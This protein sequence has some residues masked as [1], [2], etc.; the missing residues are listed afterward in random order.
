MNRYRPIRYGR[1]AVQTKAAVAIAVAVVVGTP[2]IFS[3]MQIIPAV[4]ACSGLWLIVWLLSTLVFG[5][6]YCSTVCP[7]GALT[8]L[9]SAVARRWKKSHYSYCSPST[10]TRI[11][12]LGIAAISAVTGISTIIA[13][14]D[15][16][17]AF[18]RIVAACARPA[19]IGLAGLI[20][21]AATL[22]AIVTLASWRGR[23]VCNTICPV[24][25]TLG[26]I[27]R[28][29]L[30]HADINTDLC[31]NCG[32]C[33]DVCPSQCINTTDHVVDMSRCV[34][35][36][37]CM[38]ACPS[39]AITY[40]R[41]RHQLSIP[42]MMRIGN[43]AGVSATNM[44]SADT[45]TAKPIDRRSFILT[46]VISA[47]AATEAFASK[48][49][50]DFVAGAV[51][52]YPLNHVTPPGTSSRE[53]YI[54]RCTSCGACIAACPTGVLTSS[55]KQYGL[56]HALTPVMDFDSSYCDYNCTRCTEVCPTKAIVP[57]TLAEKRNTPIGSARV[58]PTN[59]M[60]FV[61][62]T[63]CSRC[64]DVCPKRAISFISDSQGRTS[65]TVEPRLCIGCGHCSNAC[66]AEPYSAIVIEG[67]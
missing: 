27:S 61:N 25:S 40:R 13:V 20:V 55:V 18:A 21:A 51:K 49:A 6:I 5:R 36:F 64:A 62:G 46:G 38:D 15:P 53:D 4:A 47:A 31:T 58:S 35:C 26:F 43:S 23:L 48:L 52:L 12:F 54:R 33:A 11:S 67:I 7:V 3:H 56:R 66:P 39:A 57:L 65:P 22:A 60:L 37:D 41:G 19:A 45:S 9:I 14:L 24:G 44:S 8:D 29:S 10:R 17:S 2:C 16:Y 34:V 32:R 59:C 30:Y 28:L 42:M 50:P 1:I 63:P